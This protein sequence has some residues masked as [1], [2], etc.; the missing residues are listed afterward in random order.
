MEANLL[1]GITT[2]RTAPTALESLEENTFA[3]VHDICECWT[4]PTLR[5]NMLSCYR[6]YRAKAN[7]WTATSRHSIH[8]ILGIPIDKGRPP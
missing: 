5:F 8:L 3:F 7:M 4:N 6:A 2:S 1:W